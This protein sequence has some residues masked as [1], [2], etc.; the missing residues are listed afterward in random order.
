MFIHQGYAEDGGVAA[1]FDEYARPVG[2][3]LT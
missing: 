2:A 1:R 3:K